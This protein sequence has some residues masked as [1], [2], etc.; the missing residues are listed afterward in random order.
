MKLSASGYGDINT[1]KELDSSTFI[2]LIHYENYTFDYQKAVQALNK[3][4]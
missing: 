3:K 4:D 1:I 2:N